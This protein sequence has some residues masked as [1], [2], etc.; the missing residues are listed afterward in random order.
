MKRFV[1]ILLVCLLLCTAMPLSVFAADDPMKVVLSVEGFTLGEGYFVEPTEYTV[2][3][4]NDLI[5]KDGYGPFTEDTL[6]AGMATL[7]MFNDKGERIAMD[8]QVGGSTLYGIRASRHC[9]SA[10]VGDRVKE[11]TTNR[12][13]WFMIS[14]RAA[15]FPE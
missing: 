15:L 14:L 3:Q 7:A 6:T 8:V 5:K 13:Y 2:S 9:M 1:S 12:G 4:I 11:A 10:K